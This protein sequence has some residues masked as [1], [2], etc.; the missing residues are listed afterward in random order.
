MLTLLTLATGSSRCLIDLRSAALLRGALEAELVVAHP[1]PKTAIPIMAADAGFVAPMIDALISVNT[2][3]ASEA[4]QTARSAYDEVCGRSSLCRYRE[5]KTSSFETLRKQTLFADLLILGRDQDADAANLGLLK[6]A[7][8]DHRTPTVFLPPAPLSATPQ[9]VIF[10]WN[11][12]A[13]AARAIRAAL[14]IVK[15]AK[16]LI[17]LEHAGI[18]VNRSRLEH[19]LQKHG[20]A[21]ALWRNYGDQ[22][23]TARARARALLAETAREG[24]DF[25]VMGAYGEA[26]ESFFRFGRATDKVATAAK[27]PVLFSS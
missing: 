19:L 1:D 15:R 11:G 7:L 13:P 18:E 26:G 23:L 24:G 20:I 22:S 25:L 8:V 6:A 12:Q 5:T 2:A 17:V 9:T 10:S 16:K 4:T 3:T 21:P 14:P 27:I